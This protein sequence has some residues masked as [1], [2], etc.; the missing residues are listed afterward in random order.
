MG[1][2]IFLIYEFAV[3]H[4]PKPTPAHDKLNLD[5]NI[6][7]RSSP[8]NQWQFLGGNNRNE[9]ICNYSTL[10]NKH[11]LNLSFLS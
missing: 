9:I 4:D 11:K 8:I 5:S 1:R 6:K 3:G 10:N 7:Q 2:F